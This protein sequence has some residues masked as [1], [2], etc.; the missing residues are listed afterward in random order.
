[1][2]FVTPLLIP[3]A[4]AAGSEWLEVWETFCGSEGHRQ[5][6]VLTEGIPDGIEVESLVTPISMKLLSGEIRLLQH[7]AGESCW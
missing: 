4:I 2:V 5:F 3:A 1:M 7:N 6:Y